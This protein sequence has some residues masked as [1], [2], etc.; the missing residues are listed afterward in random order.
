[1]IYIDIFIDEHV[2]LNIFLSI[3][4]L[5]IECMFIFVEVKYFFL[6]VVIFVWD[7]YRV[8]SHACLFSIFIAVAIL[9]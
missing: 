3:S 5:R 1:M 4:I 9:P 8:H 6:I 7:I 2:A